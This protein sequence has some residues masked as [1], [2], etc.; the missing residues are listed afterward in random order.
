MRELAPSKAIKTKGLFKDTNVIYPPDKA[1][2]EANEDLKSP[3]KK[4]P[5]SGGP[6]P[7]KHRI[8][9]ERGE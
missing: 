6:S 8:I 4:R 5:L 2:H 1:Y 3:S 9:A 7:E